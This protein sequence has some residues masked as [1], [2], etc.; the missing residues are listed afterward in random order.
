MRI[1]GVSV[2][3][4][5]ALNEA[6]K[7]TYPDEFI[8]YHRVIDGII[9]EMVLVPGSIYGDSHSIISEW[10]SPI[11]FNKAGTAHSHPGYSNE[12]SDADIDVFCNMGGIHFITCRPYNRG[13][14]SAYDS[15]GRKVDLPMVH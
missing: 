11:D 9:S 13:S 2:D 5:D 6:A 8:C 4:I 7:S 1:T 10:M 15:H 14:W 12:P 3:F